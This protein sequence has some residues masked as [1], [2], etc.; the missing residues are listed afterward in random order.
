MSTAQAETEG[1]GKL[2]V[3]FDATILKSPAKGGWGYVIWPEAAAFF[4]TRGLVKVRGTVD[5]QPFRSSFM[6]MGGGVHKLPITNDL[7]EAIGKEVGSTVNVRLVERL[8]GKSS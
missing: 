6:A 3:E 7:R 2:D 5:G 8:D 1:M 4:G